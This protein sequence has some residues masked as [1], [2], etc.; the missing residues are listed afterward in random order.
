MHDFELANRETP[1][2]LMVGNQLVTA[3]NFRQADMGLVLQ[4]ELATVLGELGD[5]STY[6]VVVEG[7]VWRLVARER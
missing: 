4:C 6:E 5:G 3:T 7:S 1:F 2:T